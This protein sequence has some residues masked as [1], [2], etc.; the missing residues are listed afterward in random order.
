MSWTNTDFYNRT[1]LV[2]EFNYDLPQELIAQE[3]LAQREMSRMLQLSRATGEFQDRCFR[4]FPDLLRPDDL[5]VLNNTRVLPARLYG[6][7][8]GSRAQPLSVQNHA[9]RDFLKGRVEVLLT[10]QLSAHE[11]E[12]LVHP[13]KKI[14]VGEQLFFGANSELVAEVVARGTFG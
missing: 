6:H 14:G 12:C 7:R 4:E 8:S 2:S 9:S 10:K 11:W 5:V 1:M 13:G 3:P